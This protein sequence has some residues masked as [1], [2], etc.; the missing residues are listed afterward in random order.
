MIELMSTATRPITA[1]E[2]WRMPGDRRR[3]LVRGEVREMAPSGFDHGVLV[4]NFQVSLSN[5]VRAN[6][7]GIV[8]GAETGFRLSRNPDTVRGVDVGFVRADRM[9]KA[10]RP[11]SYWEGAPDLAVE[12]L[13]PNDT[14]EEIEAKVDDYFGAGCPMVLV[15]NPRRRTLTVHR[16]GQQPLV[17]RESDTFEAGEVVPGF[18]CAVAALFA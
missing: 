8:V 1:E 10:G 4:D 3:E 6:K 14:V 5:H 16:P 13:S 9:P 17:L 11:T 15:I 12:V 2:L 7:L 18:R